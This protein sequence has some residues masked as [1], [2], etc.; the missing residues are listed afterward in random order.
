MILIGPCIR[1]SGLQTFSATARP[2]FG[3]EDPCSYSCETISAVRPECH[4]R[5]IMRPA[6]ATVLMPVDEQILRRWHASNMIGIVPFLRQFIIDLKD[7]Y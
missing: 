1:P 4:A 6:L 5:E 7:D 3:H 2:I